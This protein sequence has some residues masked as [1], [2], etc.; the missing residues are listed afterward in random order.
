MTAWQSLFF[1]EG[2]IF[3][4]IIILNLQKHI[5]VTVS[6][7]L[8]HT[9]SLNYMAKAVKANQIYSPTPNVFVCDF[10]VKLP[11]SQTLL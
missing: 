8:Q 5:L 9:V 6:D 3:Y 11:H 2:K 10:V 4:L 7:N 1:T